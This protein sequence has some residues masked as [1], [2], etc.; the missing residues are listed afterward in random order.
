VAARPRGPRSPL[1]AGSSCACRVTRGNDGRTLCGMAAEIRRV[2]WRLIAMAAVPV[3]LVA[4]ATIKG[5]GIDTD[6]VYYVYAAR[7]F[8][9][10][11]HFG[12]YSGGALTIFPPGLPIFLG[13]ATKIG[14]HVQTAATALDLV[15]VGLLV[16]FTYLLARETEVSEAGSLIAAAIVALSTATLAV[17]SMVWTEPPFVVLVLVVLFVLAR[18][19][20]SGRM[21]LGSAA[22]IAV[23]ASLSEA[24]R[25]IGVSLI[26]AIVLGAFY[27]ERQRQRPRREAAVRAVGLG[28]AS[29]LGLIIVG[30]RNLLHGVGVLGPRTGNGYAISPVLKTSVS[31]MGSY[32]LAGRSD[33]AA[34]LIGI[35]IV[36]LLAFGAWRA[37]RQRD[38]AA[39]VLTTYI[40]SYW[41]VLWYGEVTSPLDPVD[42]RL[43]AP[44]MPAVVILATYATLGL[45]TELGSHLAG[46]GRWRILMPLAC[47]VLILLLL[48]GSLVRDVKTARGAADGGVGGGSYNS[49]ASLDSPLVRAVKQLPGSSGVAANSPVYLYWTTGRSGVAQIP[50]TDH[51]TTTSELEAELRGLKAVV[52]SGSVR[53]LAYIKG[54]RSALQPS[55]LAKSGIR[56]RLN[57]STSQGDLYY[58]T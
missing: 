17:F 18:A 16:V 19:V 12:Q 1:D 36:L 49:T 25:Y 3:A 40:A 29:S 43:T 56:C 4:V 33:R 27:A 31:T 39:I 15:C 37:L 45:L 21:S 48:A 32:I 58:C 34:I 7:S 14:I 24:T 28:V 35:V 42:A 13:L 6:S 54:E 30:G 57:R 9:A 22:V 47:S 20:R 10:T 5:P 50:T 46:A 52:S 11:G 38:L 2:R 23:F 8:A 51:Y 26:P 41:L 44:V 55:E 53:Y